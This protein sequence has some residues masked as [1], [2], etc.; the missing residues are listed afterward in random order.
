MRI[1][2][3]YIYKCNSPPS[4]KQNFQVWRWLLLNI[5]L[6]YQNISES[7]LIKTF[8]SRYFL[9][10]RVPTPLLEKCLDSRSICLSFFFFKFNLIYY[11]HRFPLHI[12]SRLVH[13]YPSFGNK[14]K[15]NRATCVQFNKQSRN[16]KAELHDKYT[17]FLFIVICIAGKVIRHNTI[18]CRC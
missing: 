15:Y 2:V 13:F 7:V 12:F 11:F 18:S 5:F 9:C 1:H 10:W 14:L 16:R 6:T 4:S 17:N 3:L 8:L